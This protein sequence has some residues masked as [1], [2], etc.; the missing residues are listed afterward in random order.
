M[1][2]SLFGL[3]PLG[4]FVFLVHGFLT[5]YPGSLKEKLHRYFWILEEL[6][7]QQGKRRRIMRERGFPVE[8]G[9][10]GLLVPE[11]PREKAFWRLFMVESC[12]AVAAGCVVGQI[13]ID[14]FM[15]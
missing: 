8:R 11:T 10:Y 4:V 6:P 7:S 12:M 15:G 14:F 9:E 2:L 1:T 13:S 5:G 3:L